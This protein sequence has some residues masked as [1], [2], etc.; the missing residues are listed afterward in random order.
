LR[1]YLV[2]VTCAGTYILYVQVLSPLVR[3]TWSL[4]FERRAAGNAYVA[5]THNNNTTICK[6]STEE[7]KQENS[8]DL[9][10]RIKEIS[11]RVSLNRS[12]SKASGYRAASSAI[13]A[14]TPV[15]ILAEL[16]ESQERMIAL[17]KDLVAMGEEKE[18]REEQRH[19][20]MCTILLGLTADGSGKATST[21]NA[22]A[23]DTPQFQ[24]HGKFQSYYG[25]TMLASG[26]H[27]VSC[28]MMHL[29]SILVQHPHFR[30]IQ[31]TD[32]T[33]MDIK[34]WHTICSSL[35]NA[36]KTSKAGLRVP[37]P[38]DNDFKSACRIVASPVQGR[39]P[40]CD[41][42]HIAILMLQSPELM[43]TVEWVRDAILKCTGCL[44]P[45]RQCRFRSVRHPFV[46][47]DSELDVARTAKLTM[48]TR[49]KHQEIL[50][51]KSTQRKAYMNLILEH[52]CTSDDALQR[53]KGHA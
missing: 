50:D 45:E 15:G 26:V 33:F 21:S 11:D 3:A 30:K 43:N 4:L 48:P 31:S 9:Q 53:A 44:S 18:K 2:A 5:S 7:L 17:M 49:V 1:A 52:S 46:N 23:D 28:V 35:V 51:M 10:S 24:A 38:G 39:R 41:A 36:D 40:A 47:E 13:G 6:M 37:K 14:E 25:S 12:S 19:R 32:K 42:S 8:T 34:D 22:H 27:V 29:D 16:R 20:E